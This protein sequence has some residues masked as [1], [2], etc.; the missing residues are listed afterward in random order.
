MTEKKL[1]EWRVAIHPGKQFIKIYDGNEGDS[2]TNDRSLYWEAADWMQDP[3]LVF[4]IAGY[5]R[6]VYQEPE[7]FAEE[8]DRLTEESFEVPYGEA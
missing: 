3:T 6:M 2:G 4:V 5:I 1:R 8:Y 7:R